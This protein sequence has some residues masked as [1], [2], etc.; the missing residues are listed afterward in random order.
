MPVPMPEGQGC[1]GALDVASSSSGAV[2]NHE[3]SSVK[4][5]RAKY[6][7]CHGTFSAKKLA[8]FREVAVSEVQP[9]PVVSRARCAAPAMSVGWLIVGPDHKCGCRLCFQ[10]QQARQLKFNSVAHLRDGGM[11]QI[12]PAANWNR[13]DGDCLFIIFQ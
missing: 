5:R 1:Q 7:F 4:P 8:A 12:A 13:Y 11:A 9:V 3:C 6:K 10:L 2:Q